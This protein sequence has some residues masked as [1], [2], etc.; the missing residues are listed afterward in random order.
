MT[1]EYGEKLDRNHYAKSLLSADESCINC[2]AENV[3]IDRHEIFH[4]TAYREKSKRLGLWVNLCMFCHRK[5]HQTEPELDDWLKIC[6][7]K[8]AMEYYGWTKEEFRKYFGK[9]YL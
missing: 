2:G 6:G 5:L 3:K 7:Q 4:G 8:A 9:N 1:N